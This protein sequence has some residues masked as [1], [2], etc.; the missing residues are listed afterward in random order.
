M[1]DY[2]QREYACRHYRWI[3]SSWCREYTITHKRCT[4]NV[5]HFEHKD[6]DCGECKSRKRGAVPWEHMIRRDK[7]QVY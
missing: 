3:A 2:I 6:I 7:S 4:P 1:C 5:A